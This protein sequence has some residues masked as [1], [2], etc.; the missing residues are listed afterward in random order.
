MC[1]VDCTASGGYL[2]PIQATNLGIL[3]GIPN[4]QLVLL[5][6][7]V[8]AL[9]LAIAAGTLRHVLHR[10]K[11][12]FERTRLGRRVDGYAS[13]RQ[14]R[15]KL[16]AAGAREHGQVTRPSMDTKT[17][18]RAD[19]SA[20]GIRL[21]YQRD[22]WAK[23]PTGDRRPVLPPVAKPP[24]V[25]ALDE[26]VLALAVTQMGK[27][28][29]MV[30]PVWDFPGAAVVTS[31]SPDVYTR[32]AA[33]RA[34]RGTLHRFNPD[35]LGP[36]SGP[37]RITSTFKWS[38]ILGCDDPNTAISHAGS[39]LYAVDTSAVKNEDFWKGSA[40]RILR[41]YLHA[42]ALAGKTMADVAGWAANMRDQTPVKILASNE[43]AAEG[44][45]GDLAGLLDSEAGA[46]VHSMAHT[47]QL[48]LGFMA[49]P[50]VA[51]ACMPG[52]GEQ[53]DVQAFLTS[54]ADT[55]YLLGE[56]KE[57][58]SVAPLFTCFL[59]HL[60][61]AAKKLASRQVTERLDPPVGYFLDEVANI[62]PVPLEKWTSDSLKRGITIMAAAQSRSQL[63][64]R[65][66]R[67]HF[68]TIW[69]NFTIKLIWGGF[70]DEEDLEA[71]SRM[72]G[73]VPIISVSVAA[74]TTDINPKRSKTIHRRRVLA[75]EQVAAPPNGA[76]ICKHRDTPAV[77]LHPVDWKTRPNRRRLAMARQAA[78]AP[79]TAPALAPAEQQGVPQ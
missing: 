19:E 27:T 79:A 46:T 32:T 52:P 17:R 33:L 40:V 55:L 61:D 36:E 74:E 15:A 47:L 53:F 22:L 7:G 28:S 51:A 71:I 8:A 67:D 5:L 18:R 39:I 65:Y 16:S 30:P 10:P 38:P 56:D 50:E 21:G 31:T 13:P 63:R 78:T 45:A 2:M 75:P 29:M 14:L 43:R 69:N 25:A 62:C 9:V 12:K 48:A 41:A 70:S 59:D 6:A 4:A 24:V 11:E 58:G 68:S 1:Q 3:D 77:L 44:W 57:H 37:D 26:N 49:D 73:E 72:C 42:A 20:T 23:L 34:Q 54:G 35:G 76:V 60:H 66:G 64:A